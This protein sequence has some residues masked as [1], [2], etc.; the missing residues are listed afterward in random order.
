[1]M[2]NNEKVNDAAM[3]AI[4]HFNV[5]VYGLPNTLHESGA[6]KYSIP[7]IP[8]AFVDVNYDDSGVLMGVPGSRKLSAEE[9]Y[10]VTKRLGRE[11]IL[12]SVDYAPLDVGVKGKPFTLCL[13]SDFPACRENVAAAR[14]AVDEVNKELYSNA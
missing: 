10:Q 4:K 13:H 7:F 2:Q 12:P 6:R 3:R 14:K 8:E 11:G 5:P 1:M 9:I